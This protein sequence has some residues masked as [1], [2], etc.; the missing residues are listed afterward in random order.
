MFVVYDNFSVASQWWVLDNSLVLKACLHGSVEIPLRQNCQTERILV[1]LCL[2]RY[3]SVRVHLEV[4]DNYSQ[5]VIHS[6]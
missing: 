5:D 6:R 1:C 3:T 2:T 4:Y